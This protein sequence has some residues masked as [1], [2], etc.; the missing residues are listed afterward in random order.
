MIEGIS[1]IRQTQVFRE[2]ELSSKAAE[3]LSMAIN[4]LESRLA[5]VLSI[6]PPIPGKESKDRAEMVP[7]AEKLHQL[8][9]II[10]DSTNRIRSI[11]GRIEI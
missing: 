11:I 2:L 8:N 5:E 3:N 10:S 6:E 9:N 1:T 7:L 4:D